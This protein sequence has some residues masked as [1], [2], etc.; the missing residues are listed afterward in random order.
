MYVAVL[1]DL[2]T[3]NDGKTVLATSEAIFGRYKLVKV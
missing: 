3:D 2:V 1:K